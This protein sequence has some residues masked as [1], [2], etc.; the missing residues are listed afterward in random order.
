MNYAKTAAAYREA[1][2]LGSSPEQLVVILYDH[3][4]SS[5]KRADH[6]IRV[7][8]VEGKAQALERAS[9]IVYELLASLQ[10]GEG[11]EL[12]QRLAALYS[13]IIGEISAINRTLDM[14]RL[15]RITDIVQTLHESWTAA[16]R[17]VKQGTTEGIAV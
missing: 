9:D 2:I 7:G 15:R 5:L 4:L 8:T 6:E 1:S 13:Y 16:A 10:V 3:L 11:G 14:A 12:T 17:Q